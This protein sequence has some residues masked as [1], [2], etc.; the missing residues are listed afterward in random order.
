MINRENWN[1]KRE[2]TAKI[3]LDTN[4]ALSC[5]QYYNKLR[6]TLREFN[7]YDNQSVARKRHATICRITAAGLVFIAIRAWYLVCK[8]NQ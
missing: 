6:T 5:T 2:I 1:E 3:G 8:E 4:W 7:P